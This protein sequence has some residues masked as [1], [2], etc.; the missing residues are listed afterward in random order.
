LK[1]QKTLKVD[2][3]SL[4]ENAIIVYKKNGVIYVNSVVKAINKIKVF[5][6]QGRLVVEQNNINENTASIHNM[7]A[8]NQVLIVQVTLENN[9]VINKKVEN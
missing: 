4:E 2:S 7:K 5:D 6:I 1:Y 9:K 8:T 3:K